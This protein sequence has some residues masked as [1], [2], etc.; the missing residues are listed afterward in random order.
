[1][2]DANIIFAA[3]IKDSHTRHLLLSSGWT[4]YVPEFILAEVNKYLDTLSAKT[5]LTRTEV[6]ELLARLITA[7]N[8]KIVPATEF[9]ELLPRATEVCPRPED[10]QYFALALKLRCALWSNE[11]KLKEQN[12]VTVYNT[13]EL[14]LE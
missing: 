3:L 7:A 13:Q 6:K 9:S 12:H 14:T 1:M 8:I 10:I 2:V 11:K 4:F 5:G